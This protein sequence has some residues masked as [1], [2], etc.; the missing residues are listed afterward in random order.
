LCGSAS[1]VRRFDEW[2][3]AEDIKSWD[4]LGEHA[5]EKVRDLRSEAL[6]RAQATHIKKADVQ[7]AQIFLGGFVE[8]EQRVAVVDS[9]VRFPPPET[10]GGF[11]G[12]CRSTAGVAWEAVRAFDESKDLSDEPS[13]R[14]FLETMCVLIP[15]LSGPVDVWTITRTGCDRHG[16]PR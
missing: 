3:G 11:V 16:G 1:D 13:M 8:G 12:L 15:E 14:T 2:I 10:A 6:R 9:D 5:A 7:E 4:Q